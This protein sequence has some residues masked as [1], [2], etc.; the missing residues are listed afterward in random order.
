MLPGELLALCDVVV[1]NEH[2]V[3]M[4]GGAAHLVEHGVGHVVV[5]RGAAGIDHL[6]SST[7]V[8]VEPFEV[9]PVDTT[10]AGDAFC[11]ALASRIA[12]G[13]DMPTALDF[14]AAA[15][16]LAT[17]VHGAVPSQP[18]REHIEQLVSTG[19]RR[20]HAD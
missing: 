20:A 15:G 14:A 7:S 1:P 18:R 11:G 13:D 19:V 9:H 12:A 17:T 3:T 8:H 6:T 16:A 4:L 5:T 10:G 2:E